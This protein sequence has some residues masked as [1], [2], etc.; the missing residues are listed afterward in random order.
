MSYDGWDLEQRGRSSRVSR[1]LT[2]YASDELLE[3]ARSGLEI[4]GLV[5]ELT[6]D[7]KSTSPRD[8]TGHRLRRGRVMSERA[9]AVTSGS[10]TAR[11][12][13]TFKARESFQLSFKKGEILT[14]LQRRGNWW[15]A[16]NRAGSRGRIPASY[17]QIR[18]ASADDQPD[19][20][21]D[22]SSAT[23]P[24]LETQLETVMKEL[25][26]TKELLLVVQQES[27]AKSKIVHRLTRELESASKEIALLKD[28]DRLATR[29]AKERLE[30]CLSGDC[31]ISAMATT[32]AAI[33]QKSLL[34]QASV[35]KKSQ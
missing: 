24:D 14:I 30:Q 32:R 34:A 9:E 2:K 19:E 15:F 12:R 31:V 27:I 33:R 29:L 21:E 20:A 23:A 6:M 28:H 18:D 22:E 10:L 4:G 7:E 3:A 25:D 17:V 8:S 11:A 1:S 13:L 26:R 35:E 16:A 5:H